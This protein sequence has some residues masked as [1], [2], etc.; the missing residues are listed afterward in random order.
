MS[1]IDDIF[2]GLRAEGRT[3][4]VPFLTAGFPS[5]EA[6]SAVLAALQDAGCRIVEIGFPFSDPIADGPLI[7]SS[8][9]QALRAGVTPRSVFDLVRRVRGRTSCALVAMVSVSIVHRAGPRP[10][11]DAAADVGFD[12]LIVPDL[13]LDSPLAEVIEEQ[14]ARRG[15]SLIHMVAPRT[16]DARLGRLVAR[17]SGFVYVLARAGITGERETTPD[18][19]A[20]VAAVRAH[21]DLPVAVGF[22][23]STPRQVAAVTRCADAA[24]V[25]SA[26]VRRLAD[27]GDP[28]A[29]AGEL[30][31]SLAGALSRRKG[32]PV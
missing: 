10:F 18:V 11:V 6:T 27:A 29:A 13:D 2:A 26:F 22:G 4:L 28:A 3:A 14:A 24:V 5:L 21:G 17:S 16:P 12:G 32:D 30:A 9:E 15:L 25:G 7:A 20:R 8:M 1:R 19:A 23:I 31:R